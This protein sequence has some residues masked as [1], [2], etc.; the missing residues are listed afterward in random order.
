MYLPSRFNDGE[1]NETLSFP[2][3]NFMFASSHPERD[4]CFL[5]AV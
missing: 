5:C 3:L 2:I 4:L 1:N